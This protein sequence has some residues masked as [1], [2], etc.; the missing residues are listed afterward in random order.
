MTRP[1]WKR[2]REIYGHSDSPS[3]KTVDKHLA[4]FS[5]SRCGHRLTS[6]TNGFLVPATIATPE[7]QIRRNNTGLTVIDVRTG[8]EFESIHIPGS[9]NVPLNIVEERA[10]DLVDLRG[11]TV[12]VCHS[13]ARSQNALDVL[14]RAGKTDL[15]SLE[16]GILAWEAAGGET[17]IG[18]ESKWAMDRQVRLTA[19]SLVLTGILGSIVAPKAKWLAGGVGAGLIYSAVSNTCTM[20]DVLARLPYNQSANQDVDAVLSEL[21]A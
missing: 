8:P 3:N 9:Y 11:P 7:L 19:G 17:N 15:W 5:A 16:G 4:E 14:E 12:L 2:S 10:E 21:R 18:A 20:A 1:P 13:G 6:E